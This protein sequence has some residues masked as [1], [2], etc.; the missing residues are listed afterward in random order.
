MKNSYCCNFYLWYSQLHIIYI[1]QTIS[2]QYNFNDTSNRSSHHP[3]SNNQLHI[4]LHNYYWGWKQ[5]RNKQYNCQ[6]FQHKYYIAN[7]ICILWIMNCCQCRLLYQVDIGQCSNMEKLCC[8][9]TCLLCNHLR[10]VCIDIYLRS[11]CNWHY[12][13]DIFD[14]HGSNWFHIEPHKFHSHWKNYS[15]ILCNY[16]KLNNIPGK[17]DY[18]CIQHQ[19]HTT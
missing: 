14:W 2:I 5:Y 3:Q 8:C 1:N 9:R 18:I 16:P 7:R 6:P 12:K 13:T 15:R 19:V 4:K 10:I 11:L 17:E